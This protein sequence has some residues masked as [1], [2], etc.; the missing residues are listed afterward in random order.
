MVLL[1]CNLLVGVAPL[2][3]CVKTIHLASKNIAAVNTRESLITVKNSRYVTPANPLV[4][5]D[6]GKFY[7]AIN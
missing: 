3:L 7:F 2:V 5:Q 1:P 6:A 4:A